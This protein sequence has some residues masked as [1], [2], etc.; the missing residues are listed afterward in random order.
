MDIDTLGEKLVAVLIE[1]GLVETPADLYSLGEDALLGLPKV[2][3]ERVAFNAQSARALV[4]R[5]VAVRDVPLAQLLAALDLPQVGLTTAEAIAAELSSLA[6]IRE[7]EERLARVPRVGARRAR[8]I[9]A[10]LDEPANRALVRDLTRL[11]VWC[12]DCDEASAGHTGDAGDIG[13]IGEPDTGTLERDLLRLVGAFGIK[14]IGAEAVR[15]LVRGD[16]VSRPADVFDLSV[17]KLL[18]LPPRVSMRRPFGEKSAENLLGQIEP[19]KGARLDRFLF[20]LGI[21]NVGAHVARVL[22]A[23]FGSVDEVRNATR[24]ML[25]EVH[26][27]GE[28]VAD[29][30]A[31]FFENET[32]IGFLETL[33]NEREGGVA[34]RW[35]DTGSSTLAGKRIV[36]TGTLPG[37]SREEATALI[38]RHGGGVISSVSKKTSL[39]VAGENPGSKLAKAEALGVRVMRVESDDDTNQLRDLASGKI[40]LSEVES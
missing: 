31:S 37:M 21:P 3:V 12:G 13:D 2:Q 32:N 26:E 16:L 4:E 23:R 20:A 30:V 11:G 10:A 40:Q 6:E 14:G 1:N 29:S 17:E 18:D 27:I 34:P 38:E 35:E 9:C 19:S 39:V 8:E 25:L 28:E 22:A 7:G 36:L 15:A 33:L 24:D 5:L